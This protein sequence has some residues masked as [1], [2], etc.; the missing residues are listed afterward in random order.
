MHSPQRHL[1]AGLKDCPVIGALQV[2]AIDSKK[3]VFDP[4]QGDTNVGAPVSVSV[5]G[6][7]PSTV[8]SLM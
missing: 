4:V 2:A 7:V 8:S 5:V 6:N 3:L 1:F